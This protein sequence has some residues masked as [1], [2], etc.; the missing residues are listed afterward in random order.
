MQTFLHNLHEILLPCDLHGRLHHHH[1][2]HFNQSLG[3][4][5]LPSYTC[6]M[7]RRDL[8]DMYT[9]AQGRVQTYQANHDR[10]YACYMCYVT[11]LSESREQL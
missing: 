10:T 5:L 6:H 2:H 7:G 4:H 9:R 8:P 3:L 1:H 11:S